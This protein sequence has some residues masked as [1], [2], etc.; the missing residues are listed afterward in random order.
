MALV[1]P[2]AGIV[3]AA[4]GGG[5]DVGAAVAGEVSGAVGTGV[6]VSL[7]DER[8]WPTA[9]QLKPSAFPCAHLRMVHGRENRITSGAMQADCSLER[10]RQKQGVRQLPLPMHCQNQG[11][12]LAALNI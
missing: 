4:F 12:P 7:V 1:S 8:V 2:P 10:D 9:M 11:G 3:A 6:A 5:D